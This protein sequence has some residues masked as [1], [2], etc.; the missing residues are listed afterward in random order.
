MPGP[1][2][3]PARKLRPDA[4]S[5]MSWTGFFRPEIKKNSARRTRTRG[6]PGRGLR[7]GSAG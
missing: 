1:G 4:S 7:L 2:P 3:S 5:G 6:H